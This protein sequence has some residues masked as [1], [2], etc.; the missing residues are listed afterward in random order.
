MAAAMIAGMTPPLGMALS[1]FAAP[2]KYPDEMYENAKSAVVLGFS[3][4]T[5]G[6]IPYAASD[7]ARV[8][9]S[10]M[11]GSATA[12]AASMAMGV[13]MPAPH[14]GIFV[15]PLS[16][17]P[18]GFLGALALGSVVTAAMVTLLKSDVVESEDT[19]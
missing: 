8:I 3:F 9:P 2:Q 10:L 16:N 14:G 5:E 18:L 19:P 1:N 6:A 17:N 13:S 7:P 12:A 4:I 15:V 11:A